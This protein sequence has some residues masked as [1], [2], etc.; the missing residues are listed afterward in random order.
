LRQSLSPA[1]TVLQE[2]AAAMAPIAAAPA[3][4]P[5]ENNL[6]LID[7]LHELDT[8][9]ATRNM[10]AIDINAVL[11]Q[12]AA[13]IANEPFAALDSAVGKLDFAAARSHV[14]AL[15]SLLSP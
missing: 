1:L 10:R 2:L 3:Q 5:P 11:Q 6:H 15:I 9:L 8:L 7:L 12:A 13:G 14:A 4:P